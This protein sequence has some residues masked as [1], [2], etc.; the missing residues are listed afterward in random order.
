M[1]LRAN[2]KIVV[3]R[4]GSEAAKKHVYIGVEKPL[5]P[6]G[7]IIVHH[8]TLTGAKA[9]MWERGWLDGLAFWRPEKMKEEA[10]HK[11]EEEYKKEENN[12]SEL[13]RFEFP[14]PKDTYQVFAIRGEIGSPEYS[15]KIKDTFISV[16]D[17][18][19]LAKT[20]SEHPQHREDTLQVRVRHIGCHPLFAPAGNT[21][22]MYMCGVEY[23]PLSMAFMVG[24][25]NP[26]A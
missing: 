9:E 22:V 6:Y 18:I 13:P 11:R 14:T 21:I 1:E 2:I 19:T 24:K 23:R 20:L 5:N 17:A 3:H 4:Q 12:L 26:L 15:S 8:K 7:S 16:T 25:K 10:R